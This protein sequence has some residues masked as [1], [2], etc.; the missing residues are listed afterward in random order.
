VDSNLGVLTPDQ[1][2]VVE[3]VVTADGVPQQVTMTRT[4]VPSVAGDEVRFEVVDAAGKTSAFVLQNEQCR[5]LNEPAAFP[6][7]FGETTSI[8]FKP[9]FEASRASLHV[10]TVAGRKIREV[11]QEGL[12]PNVEQV[13][14]WDGRDDHGLLVANGTYLLRIT[15]ADSRCA[16]TKALPVV[17]MR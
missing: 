10:Y 9:A 5:F 16:L 8:V 11:H 6:N 15:A 1:Y 7:P 2:Q 13:L 12:L 17:L 14:E 3:D 4:Y